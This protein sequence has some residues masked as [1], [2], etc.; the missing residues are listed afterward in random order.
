MIW[1]NRLGYVPEGSHYY[2]YRLKER[3]MEG[4]AGCNVRRES[5]LTQD[6]YRACFLVL[7]EPSRN[8]IQSSVQIN[9]NQPVKMK[10]LSIFATV[11]FA[12]AASAA[13]AEGSNDASV[14]QAKSAAAICVDNA[15]VGFGGE[16]LCDDRVC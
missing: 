4:V 5:A 1:Q 9:S 16:E 7:I 11:A 13:P 10:F 15:C 12:V 6:I 14:E 2:Y 3:D 8:L